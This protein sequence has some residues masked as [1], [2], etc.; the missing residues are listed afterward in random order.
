VRT[1]VMR[2]TIHLVT[3]EDCLVLRPLV[4]PVLDAELRRHRDF[5]PALEGVDIGPVLHHGRTVM[6]ERPCS[7]KELRAAFA[8]RFPELDPAQFVGHAQLFQ[9]DVRSHGGRTRRP[10][11]LVQGN[12]SSIQKSRCPPEACSKQTS[13]G[14]CLCPEKMAIGKFLRHLVFELE[15]DDTPRP[16]LLGI[17][18]LLEERIGRQPLHPHAAPAVCRPALLASPGAGANS[19]AVLN[20]VCMVS[21]GFL[22]II[23]CTCIVAENA[24]EGVQSILETLWEFHRPRGRVRFV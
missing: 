10:E 18:D 7:G 12:P 13:A 15:A 6:A 22:A 20:I 11:Q 19:L 3:A 16:I 8:A 14:T 17:D 9:K 23:Q 24:L 2:A 4:Q 5:A 1:V 21:I